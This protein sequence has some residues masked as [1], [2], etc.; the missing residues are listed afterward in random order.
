[1]TRRIT[2]LI[3]IAAIAALGPGGAARATA[4]SDG[5]TIV[6]TQQASDYTPIAWTASGLATATGPVSD[7]GTW[8]RGLIRF[9]GG[10]SPVFAGIIKTVLTGSRG[11]FEMDFQGLGSNVTGAFSGTWQIKAGTG[12]Y[13]HLHGS[14][15]WYEDD[16]T[17]GVFRFPCTGTVRSD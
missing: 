6:L 5:V 12:A 1:M 3:G 8:D 14:G 11:S 10:R 15:T 9:Q 4:P 13:A 7:S 2:I 16:S 17:P